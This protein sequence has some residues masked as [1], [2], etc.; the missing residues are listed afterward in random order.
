MPKDLLEENTR[1]PLSKRILSSG[2]SRLFLG[3]MKNPLSLSN[4]RV[5]RKNSTL[6]KFQQ[7][8]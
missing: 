6:K 2:L 8:S 1:N 3:L 4:T 5:K 7:W